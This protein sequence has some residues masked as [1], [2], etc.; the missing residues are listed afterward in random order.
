MSKNENTYKIE[1]S[2]IKTIYPAII[3]LTVV[4]FIPFIIMVIVSFTNYSTGREN[5]IFTGF[6]NY[7]NSIR[8]GTFLRLGLNTLW[9]SGLTTI[10]GVTV[11]TLLGLT[12]SNVKGLPKFLVILLILPWAI[13]P[14]VSALVW[15]WMLDDINGVLN[16]VLLKVGFFRN[17]IPWLG[18]EPFVNYAILIPTLWRITPFCALCIYISRLSIKQ[19]LYGAASLD[20]ARNISIFYYVTWPGIRRT[21]LVCLVFCCLW[22]ATEFPLIYLLTK[23]G[24]SNSTHIFTTYAFE[25]S[26]RGGYS[27]GYG[28]SVSLFL[29]PFCLAVALLLWRFGLW[30]K[31]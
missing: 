14:T 25:V 2:S 24:P 15:L 21:V 16:W 9:Y 4:V 8:S 17:Q 7:Y 29:L 1:I 10:I 28:S 6:Q 22:S 3:Y 30:H 12:I 27:I 19:N 23:G 11:G 31:S 5:V 26:L 13:P 20:G 18:K